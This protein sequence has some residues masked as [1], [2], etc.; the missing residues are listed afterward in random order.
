MMLLAPNIFSTMTPT[1][2]KS[3]S[4]RCVGSPLGVE[5]PGRRVSF[6]PPVAVEAEHAKAKAK[7]PLKRQRR[8]EMDDE[9]IFAGW[10]RGSMDDEHIFVDKAIVYKMVRRAV[11]AAKAIRPM[12][13]SESTGK[14]TSIT[15]AIKELQIGHEELKKSNEGESRLQAALETVATMQERVESLQGHQKSLQV[16]H[17]ELKKSSG[18]EAHLQAALETIATTQVSIEAL[19]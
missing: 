16:E 18:S 3:L 12:Q 13:G 19:Q 15:N 8:D 11:R 4:F 7:L 10:G 17:D 5:E 2:I 6:G 1:P 14:R 9:Q